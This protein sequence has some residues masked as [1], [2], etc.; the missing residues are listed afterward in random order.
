MSEID[1]AIEFILQI[2]ESETES[3]CATIIQAL[4]EKQ[5]SKQGCEYCNGEKHTISR[6]DIADTMKIYYNRPVGAYYFYLEDSDSN[7]GMLNCEIKFCPMCGR[8]LNHE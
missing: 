7:L 5:Q 3:V 2:A 1:K 6:F 8:R 4:E